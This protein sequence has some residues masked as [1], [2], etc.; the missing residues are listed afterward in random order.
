[1]DGEAYVITFGSLGTAD[2]RFAAPSVDTDA[3]VGADTGADAGAEHPNTEPS[4][5][6]LRFAC[7]WDLAHRNPYDVLCCGDEEAESGGDMVDEVNEVDEQQFGTDC[8]E[9][10]LRGTVWRKWTA[11][12]PEDV[13]CLRGTVWKRWTR[14]MNQGTG[15]IIPKK[16][17]GGGARGRK[18]S[19]CRRRR[20]VN[21][22]RRQKKRHRASRYKK[23]Q[24]CGR[25]RVFQRPRVAMREGADAEVDADVEK[26]LQETGEK[27]RKT[28]G[29]KKLCYGYLKHALVGSPFI[30]SH[31]IPPGG[32][33]LRLVR[34]GA[35]REDEDED[36]DVSA[37]QETRSDCSFNPVSVFLYCAYEYLDKRLT[38]KRV[39]TYCCVC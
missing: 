27:K 13:V 9:V 29:T 28:F 8:V 22:R 5:Q 15:W 18:T 16:N 4:A 20:Q 1:M 23:R 38:T 6:A 2:D 19:G 7:L 36:A 30:C 39:I 12:A 34:G 26:I 31:G 25:V 17:I 11:S 35:T 24:R 3:G 37:E 32:F 10:C 21:R 33:G 14:V